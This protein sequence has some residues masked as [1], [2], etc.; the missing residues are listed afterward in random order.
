MY[1]VISKFGNPLFPRSDNLV[2]ILFETEYLFLAHLYKFW[3]E[4]S[5]EA[6]YRLSHKIEIIKY[7]TSNSNA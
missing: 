7:E 3:Y 6:G 5:S 1:K 2:T 4:S